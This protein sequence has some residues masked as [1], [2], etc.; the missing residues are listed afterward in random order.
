[1]LVKVSFSDRESRWNFEQTLRDY[2]S[3][4]AVQSYPNPIRNEMTAFRNALL[5]RY[6][7]WLI[8]TRPDR[9]TLELIAFKKRV[10]EPKWQRISKVHPLPS[11]IML[12]KYATPD[13]IEKISIIN[14]V[15]DTEGNFILIDVEH[16][17]SRFTLGSVYRANTN[18]GIHTVCMICFNK[19]SET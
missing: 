8:M 18:E 17:N 16:K 6:L 3:M 2:T 7:G 14:M 19:T 1:M 9:S 5:D 10:G 11:N 12:P 15:R 4:H 13:H